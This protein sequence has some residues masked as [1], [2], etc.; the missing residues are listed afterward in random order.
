MAYRSTAL[1]REMA[2]MHFEDDKLGKIDVVVRSHVHY[3]WHHESVNRHG[4]ITPAWKFADYHLFRGG[5]AGT[6]PDIG[7]VL[8]QV[9]PNGDIYVDKFIKDVGVKPQQV[10]I[11]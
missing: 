2:N 10:H 4:I 9:E 11:K 6:T 8:A 1:A 3:F 7:M 5:V